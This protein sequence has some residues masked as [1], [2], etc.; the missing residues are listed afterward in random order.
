MTP[1]IWDSI[2]TDALGCFAYN[3]SAADLSCYTGLTGSGASFCTSCMIGT[4]RTLLQLIPFIY[5][6]AIIIGAIVVGYI[7]GKE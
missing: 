6:G 2:Y 7:K 4:S 5:V 3:T 1:V